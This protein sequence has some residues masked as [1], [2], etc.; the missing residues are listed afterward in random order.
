LQKKG[1]K[2]LRKNYACYWQFNTA[3]YTLGVLKIFRTLTD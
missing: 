2:L 1:G 3:Y